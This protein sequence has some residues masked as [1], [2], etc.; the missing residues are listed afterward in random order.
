[1]NTE[2]TIEGPDDIRRFA[3]RVHMLATS[4]Y[5]LVTWNSSMQG[6]RDL[7]GNWRRVDPWICGSWN[8]VRCFVEDVMWDIS[9]DFGRIYWRSRDL[10]E[11]ADAMVRLVDKVCD[12]KRNARQESPSAAECARRI[13]AAKAELER[14]EEF[15]RPY[16]RDSHRLKRRF[17][18]MNRMLGNAAKYAERYGREVPQ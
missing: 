12:D 10:S 2:V 17:R 8:H 5:G 6:Y 18:Y 9:S 14:F 7:F 11:L 15:V 1:M 3:F 16:Y 4:I 13:L